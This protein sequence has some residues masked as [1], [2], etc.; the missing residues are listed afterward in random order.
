MPSNY[1]VTSNPFNLA[2]PPAGFL[3][4]LAAHDPELRIFASTSEPLYRI[5]RVQLHAR[6][7]LNFLSQF[8]DTKINID[9][10]MW[11]VVSVHPPNLLGFSWAK[12]ILDLQERDQHQF[13]S[14][15]EVDDRVNQFEAQKRAALDATQ[16]DGADQIAADLYKTYKTLTGSRVSLAHKKHEGART[17]GR[18]LM[19]RPYRPANTGPG[20]LFVGR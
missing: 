6:G 1:I 2:T 18:R 17:G 20:A 7:W 15:G 16:E 12:V 9:H 14:G 5:S 10:G 11:P 13:G 19:S 4:A 8:P 3:A